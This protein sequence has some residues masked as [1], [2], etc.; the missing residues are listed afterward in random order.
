MYE[1]FVNEL[2]LEILMKLH[3][4]KNRGKKYWVVKEIYKDRV[5][6]YVCICVSIS[7]IL[8]Q[9]MNIYFGLSYKVM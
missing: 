3:D 9:T 4:E 8:A 7:D 6:I 1:D 5:C 2:L